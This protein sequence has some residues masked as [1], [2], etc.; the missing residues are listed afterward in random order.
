MIKS[1]K[2]KII[3]E[4]LKKVGL[5]VTP[6][7]IAILQEILFNHNHPSTDQVYQKVHNKYPNISFDTVNRTLITLSQKGTLKVVEG[8]GLPKKY[9]PNTGPHH[10]FQC[11]QCHTIIDFQNPTYD[12]IDV[13]RELQ[14]K[15]QIIRKKVV[16]EGL[17][18]KCRKK[19]GDKTYGKSS[20]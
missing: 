16:L 15:Y 5:K 11:I 1:E 6:Q 9:D 14:D 19:G 3:S 17:C 2:I 4:K 7:R 12:A 8:Y 10:H 18:D 13:P 20:Y